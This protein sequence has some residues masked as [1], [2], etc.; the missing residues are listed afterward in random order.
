MFFGVW[1][2]ITCHGLGPLII[3]DGRLNSLQYINI[4]DDHLSTAFQKFPSTQL[5][6]ILYQQDN[7]GPHRS[8]MTQNYLQENRISLLQWPANSPDLNIMENIWSIVDNRLLKLPINNIDD[9]KSALQHVWTEI[10]HNTIEKLFKSM[11]QRLRQVIN[12]KGFSC[13]S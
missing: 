4:L 3:Y 11:P 8:A 13:K 5:Q 7:A 9:L 1:S 10:S 12:F 6:K 2:Y